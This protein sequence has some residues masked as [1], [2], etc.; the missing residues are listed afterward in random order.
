MTKRSSKVAETQLLSDDDT[1]DI[2]SKLHDFHISFNSN[3]DKFKSIACAVKN[4][5]LVLSD[6]KFPG[7]SLV[8]ICKQSFLESDITLGILYRNI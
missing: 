7:F 8:T 5:A 1:H 3:N 4:S 2:C 6:D